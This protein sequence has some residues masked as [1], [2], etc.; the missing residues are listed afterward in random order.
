MKYTINNEIINV[1]DNI[2]KEYENAAKEKIT[3]D[4]ITTYYLMGKKININ[5]VNEYIINGIKDEI[6]FLSDLPN[7]VHKIYNG[8]TL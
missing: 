6:A 8:D 5:N 7:T 1:P 3:Q 2:L 4:K